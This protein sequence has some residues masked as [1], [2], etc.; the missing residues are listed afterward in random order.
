MEFTYKQHFLKAQ[1]FANQF[2]GARLHER[3]ACPEAVVWL[4]RECTTA[5]VCDLA[6]AWDTCP[7]GDWLAWV[8]W[9]LVQ[10][11]MFD[12]YNTLSN[13]SWRTTGNRY[14]LDPFSVGSSLSANQSRKLNRY[15]NAIRKKFPN[16]W[17][18]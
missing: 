5:G 13:L 1:N 18:G 10:T 3:I 14:F 15:A 11:K 7:R 16:P 12:V 2:L 17:K 4:Q 8:L 9:K 6:L